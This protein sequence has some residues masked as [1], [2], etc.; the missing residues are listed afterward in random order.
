MKIYN[1]KRQF[2]VNMLYKG[3]WALYSTEKQS[4]LGQP[5]TDAPYAFSGHRI[6][7]ERQDGSIL[8]T[9]KNW[10]NT[11][12]KNVDVSAKVDQ[13][14]IALNQA[15]KSTSDFDVVAKIVQMHELDDYT[16]EL[17]I[18]DLSG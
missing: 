11:T 1:S 16:N 18:R 13:K 9:L 4:P 10:T 12:F 7:Q 6:T 3:S 5:T 17:K 15:S 14:T 8:S 2:N